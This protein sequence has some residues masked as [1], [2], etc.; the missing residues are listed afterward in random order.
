M[1]NSHYD[2]LT[3]QY[4]SWR[5]TSGISPRLVRL[6]AIA[7]AFLF[8]ATLYVG[9]VYETVT[10]PSAHI[11]FVGP[12]VKAASIHPEDD[13]WID[14]PRVFSATSATRTAQGLSSHPNSVY[15][16]VISPERFLEEL[17]KRS[18]RGSPL[19]VYYSG[20]LSVA[21]DKSAVLDSSKQ[22]G[23]PTH[24]TEICDLIKAI[25]GCD[26][27]I[28]ILV[29]DLSMPD[30]KGPL[31]L[32]ASHCFA[33]AQIQIDMALRNAGPVPTAIQFSINRIPRWHEFGLP[34]D[35]TWER[36]ILP[37]QSECSSQ[38]IEAVEIFS[39]KQ[40]T[41]IH[42]FQETLS[43]RASSEQKRTVYQ[44]QSEWLC[45][46]DWP[47]NDRLISLSTWN[48]RPETAE[49]PPANDDTVIESL[50][51]KVALRKA[52]ED[53]QNLLKRARERNVD[54]GQQ[55]MFIPPSQNYASLQ[56]VAY[57]FLEK[58]YFLL[59][60]AYELAPSSINHEGMQLVVQS[61]QDAWDS[62]PCI[63]RVPKWLTS[64]F[65]DR[66]DSQGPQINSIVSR[67]VL[68]SY[69]LA[70]PLKESESEWLAKL[71]A[72]LESPD[73]T[74]N[75][76]HMG[77]LKLSADQQADFFE[78]RWIEAVLSRE[79]LEASILR[80]LTR[81]KLME[82]RLTSDPLITQEFGSKI[83]EACQ[84][85]IATE[86]LLFDKIEPDW[87]RKGMQSL[88]LVQAK[89]DACYA[90]FLEFR[91]QQTKSIT[92]YY[93]EIL[94][95]E[96]FSF[97]APQLEPDGGVTSDEEVLKR[98]KNVWTEFY[99]KSNDTE[100]TLSTENNRKA[101]WQNEKSFSS[102][103]SKKIDFV[104]QA[105]RIYQQ[106]GDDLNR[107]RSTE[108]F[109]QPNASNTTRS[110][111]FLIAK[112]EFHNE[113]NLH[114]FD[115]KR[116]ISTLAL[117]NV[118]RMSNAAQGAQTWEADL[119]ASSSACW[120]KIASQLASRENSDHVV[121][122]FEN[123]IR[124]E[125]PLKLDFSAKD[126]VEGVIGIQ[127]ESKE[128][129]Q[130]FISTEYDESRLQLLFGGKTLPN[131]TSFPLQ[132]RNGDLRPTSLPISVRKRNSSTSNS[133][134]IFYV[135][136]GGQKRRA[137]L[138]S[139]TL[140]PQM[141]SVGLQ[142]ESQE[143]D[144]IASD[145]P[146]DH[147]NVLE[148]TVP[149]NKKNQMKIVAK[150]LDFQEAVISHRVLLNQSDRAFP[151]H[152]VVDQSK[153]TQVLHSFGV[154][155]VAA[156][157]IPRLYKPGQLE[158]V[159]FL[160]DANFASL[161]DRS[162]RELVLESTNETTKHVQYTI[163][164]TK[165][166]NPRQFIHAS[167]TNHPGSQMLELE[168]SPARQSGFPSAGVIAQCEL[169]DLGAG[170][171]LATPQCIID[172]SSNKKSIRL[173]TAASMS[174]NL[175]VNIAIDDWKSAFVF[176]IDRDQSGHYEP[177]TS[178]VG[179]AI[180][181]AGD[182]S[183]IA[184]DATHVPIEMDLCINESTFEA[185]RDRIH[186]GIDQNL[187]RTL[188]GESVVEVRDTKSHQT[189]FHGVDAK[190]D[191]IL[192]SQVGSIHASIPIEFEWN[193]KGAVL[194]KI[195]R[196]GETIYSHGPQLIFDKLKPKIRS[197]QVQ[198]AGPAILGKPLAI[199]VVTDDADLSG[200]DLVEGGWSV[201]GETE[202]HDRMTMVPALSNQS[203]RW[204]LTLPTATN[205]PG[206]N[207]LLIRSRDRAGSISETYSLNI[208]ITTEADYQQQIASAVTIVR[209]RLISD[210]KL[211]PGAKLTLG[212]EV[213]QKVEKQSDQPAANSELKVIA[214][215]M[216][217]DNGSFLFRGIP[218]GKYIVE[219][220]V[221]LRGT[222]LVQ[223]TPIVVDALVGPADCSITVGEKK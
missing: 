131:G 73:P 22:A 98:Y 56:P 105:N 170:R 26:A 61:L 164:K 19:I 45:S 183:V 142:N 3:V 70:A 122:S 153:A 57:S 4:Q 24:A 148:P 181:V 36:P 129:S 62:K 200:V 37:Q 126:H 49:K 195:V 112:H 128:H 95:L 42:A 31:S 132:I 72:S 87:P 64:Y 157:A 76:L 140:V 190:G 93:N 144:Q 212:L 198:S 103:T 133:P 115:P 168:F 169:W 104:S 108:T 175:L 90:E 156:I 60:T 11:F 188:D 137:V 79:G 211:M 101:D 197:V 219:S 99:F 193:R 91:S 7:L 41:E 114:S 163:V 16:H 208:A 155:P 201:T 27:S 32:A 30:L 13:W 63:D 20:I 167:V 34:S 75:P 110:S 66:I 111:S 172:S 206:Y 118:Q 1:M 192:E 203:N 218:S 23:M 18:F 178:F 121:E 136:H 138:E 84:Q 154:M 199:E 17:K 40:N 8:S 165:A 6:G 123:T 12:T 58:N 51:P 220:N 152:G 54:E 94:N 222:R 196:S 5:K 83:I 38:F 65:M 39:R 161:S 205:L 141:L 184:T 78:Y 116:M 160:P 69:G 92:S 86:R 182:S 10:K 100:R 159:V 59:R 189:V 48:K 223:R 33:Q 29:F 204:I 149:A 179:A 176:E 113:C 217:D 171:L 55:W 210:H 88:K 80:E 202:F 191:L 213:D 158:T 147:G 162:F 134:V 117:F 85:L 102:T 67:A 120:H 150:N 46:P 207:T 43:K 81:A 9:L 107:N 35:L 177:D 71:R 68:S 135:T 209:G 28:G 173:S 74:N 119:L 174:K 125:A 53:Y 52:L 77:L 89:F 127:L 215:T 15:E 124:I 2:K 143:F 214:T 130:A 180:R 21:S 185:S 50:T 221:I 96:H 146:S 109:S 97:P 139:E 216:S 151:L 187:D 106:F 47:L 44:A 194:A 186:I 145:F 14:L 82:L 166:I 25:K